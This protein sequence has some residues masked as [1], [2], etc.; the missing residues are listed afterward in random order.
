MTQETTPET[1]E[2]GATGQKPCEQAAAPA[3]ACEG[4]PPSGRRQ[5]LRDLRRQLTDQDLTSPGAQ[6]LLLDELERVD[7]ECELL[8]GYV[9]RFHDADKRA[10]VLE[11]RLRTQTAL[12]VAFGVGVGVGGAIV[13]LAPSFWAS[14]PRGYI[15]LGVGLLLVLGGT[16]ARVVKR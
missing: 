12:E 14:P 1:P 2:A 5:A 6:K 10:A 4:T 7:A 8:R 15:A 11:E 13:G 3:P 16:V 9:T